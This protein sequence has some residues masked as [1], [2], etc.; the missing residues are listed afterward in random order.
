[1]ILE[2]RK[3]DMVF[4]VKDLDDKLETIGSPPSPMSLNCHCLHTYTQGTDDYVR[5]HFCLSREL[6]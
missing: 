2:A 3:L 4:V 1:M 5:G 6:T